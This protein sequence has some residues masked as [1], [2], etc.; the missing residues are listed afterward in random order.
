MLEALWIYFLARS[1]LL[2]LQSQ[3]G[4]ARSPEG[5]TYVPGQVHNLA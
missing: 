1:F 2:R 3:L 5:I 4:H